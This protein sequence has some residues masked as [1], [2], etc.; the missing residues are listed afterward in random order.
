VEQAVTESKLEAQTVGRNQIAIV[1]KIAHVEQL[2]VRREAILPAC[3]EV[4]RSIVKLA[5]LA[6]KGN[7]SRIIE[8]CLAKDEDTVFGQA[9]A[10][11]FNCFGRYGT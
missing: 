2:R 1:I 7:V 5:Q 9:A 4:G 6:S 10:D 8:L 3:F 11:F